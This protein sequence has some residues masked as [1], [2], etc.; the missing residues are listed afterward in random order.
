MSKTQANQDKLSKIAIEILIN[1]IVNN[2][3]CL[4]PLPD[5]IKNNKPTYILWQ[6]L[7][8]PLFLKDL[9]YLNSDSK[10]GD[11]EAFVSPIASFFYRKYGQKEFVVWIRKSW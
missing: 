4:Y 9:I 10:E 11:E 5:N 2:S 8:Y 3:G 1:A 6:K 7:I